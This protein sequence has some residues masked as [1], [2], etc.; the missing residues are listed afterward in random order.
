MQVGCRCPS[1]LQGLVLEASNRAALGSNIDQGLGGRAVLLAAPS[2]AFT[3][4]VLLP[5]VGC[6]RRAVAPFV[7]R[8]GLT[9]QPL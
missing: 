3:V 1:C 5:G 2:V 4:P 9:F 7:G 6:F 8:A